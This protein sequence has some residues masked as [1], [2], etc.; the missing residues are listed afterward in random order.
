VIAAEPGV[1]HGACHSCLIFL[2]SR[3]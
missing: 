2:L 1:T 3:L